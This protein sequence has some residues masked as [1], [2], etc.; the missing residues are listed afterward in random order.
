MT[1]IEEAT[2]IAGSG[3]TG[4]H[5]GAAGEDAV[6][7]QL[8]ALEAMSVEKLRITWRRLYRAE[9]PRRATRELLTLAVAWKIQEQA[10]GGLTAATRRHLAY[11]ATTMER[12]GDVK[13]ARVARLK[14]G[15][16]LVRE[17]RGQ[18]HTIVVTE[19]G[20]TWQGRHWQSLSVI[21]RTI[22]GVR[23]SGPRFFGLKDGPAGDPRA[24]STEPAHA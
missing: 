22:T 24:A 1:N 15:A 20:F 12:D 5:R 18:T 10:Y 19:D 13:R 6:T 14:P 17:W 3:G 7:A 11:L 16:R 21:A 4:T 23:W 8:R 9:P 2:A